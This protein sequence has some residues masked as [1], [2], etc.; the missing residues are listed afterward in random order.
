MF[1][2]ISKTLI[3]ATHILQQVSQLD[4]WNNVKKPI[5]RSASGDKSMEVFIFFYIYIKLQSTLY[6]AKQNHDSEKLERNQRTS[7]CMMNKNKKAKNL[8]LVASENIFADG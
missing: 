8:T 7:K 2:S 5:K 6:I 3:G 4:S 1:S